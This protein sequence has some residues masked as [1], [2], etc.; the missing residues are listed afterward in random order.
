[1]KINL[2]DYITKTGRMVSMTEAERAKIRGMLSEYMAM[3][4]VRGADV[5][6]KPVGT[7]EGWYFFMRKPVALALLIAL[8]ASGAG[9]S[10]A[11]ER[12]LPGDVLY[13]VKVSVNEEVRGALA[14]T[15][16]AKASWEAERAQKRLA[17]AGA[18]AAKGKLTE[19]AEADIAAR[20]EKYA[21]SAAEKVAQLEAN[22]SPAAIGISSGFETELEAHAEILDDLK[23]GEKIRT[24][25]R[26]KAQKFALARSNAETA[27]SVSFTP[28][29][30]AVS[31]EPVAMMMKAAPI[32]SAEQARESSDTSQDSAGFSAR[33]AEPAPQPDEDKVRSSVAR[34]MGDSAKIELKAVLKLQARSGSKFISEEKDRIESTIASAKISIEESDTAYARGDYAFAFH[35]YQDAFVSL[36]KLEVF[37]NAAIKANIKILIKTPL[38]IQ[39]EEEDST[40]SHEG[41]GESRVNVSSDAPV[42]VPSSGVIDRPDVETKSEKSGSGD[43]TERREDERGGIV[44]ALPLGL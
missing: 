42:I 4:P 32:P 12:A 8:V 15:A 26:E 29:V 2:T 36:K 25:I 16:E 41:R 1:M 21:D 31:A 11:S 17:E 39:G 13:P 33:S 44:P 35:G 22:D 24:L 10:Y 5:N 27:A 38:P 34:K 19:K 18:L 3:K 40:V 20:F 9:I 6:K 14:T 30:A 43:S 28:A 37:L 23:G 7:V